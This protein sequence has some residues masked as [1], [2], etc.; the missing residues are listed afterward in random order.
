MRI[1]RLANFVTS[2]SG[3]LRTALRELGAG[4]RTA[5]HEPVLVVPGPT[6]RDEDTEQ[7]RIITVA[8]PVAPGLGGYRVLLGRRRIERLFDALAPDRLEV[9]DRTTLR[10]VGEWGRRQ[11]V[12]AVMVAHESLLAA[13]AAKPARFTAAPANHHRS[14]ASVSTRPTT[15][16]RRPGRSAVDLAANCCSAAAPANNSAAS[17]ASPTLAASLPPTARSPHRN[18]SESSVRACQPGEAP[19][20]APRT[21]EVGKE[22]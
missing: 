8:G 14:R 16:A 15:G 20:R 10:W 13:W 3:G 22:L 19:L 11:G 9:S 18:T 5:G 7:G 21:V 4:Y 17:S 1:V 6:D 12:P 2:Q